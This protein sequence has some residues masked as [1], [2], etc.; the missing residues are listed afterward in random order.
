MN[1]TSP[2][3]GRS[4]AAREELLARIRADLASM[5]DEEDEAITRAAESDPDNLPNRPPKRMGRPP[6]ALTKEAVTIRL[7]RDV[8]AHFKASGDG[9]Q[10]RINEAL[11]KVAAL[12]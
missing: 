8:I 12:K 11:R 2:K 4:D 5:T 6:L 7:D 1:N 9:W 3:A 10:T